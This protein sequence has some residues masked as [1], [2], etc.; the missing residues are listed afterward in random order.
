MFPSAQ[1][2]SWSQVAGAQYYCLTVGTSQ[3][4]VDLVNSGL[5]PASQLSYTVPGTPR[6]HPHCGPGSTPTCRATWTWADV[7][8]SVTG[9]STAT[10]TRPTA[11]A[12]KSTPAQAFS[13]TP[14]ASA[15]YYADHSRDHPGWLRP[16]QQRPAAGHA[17]RSFTCPPSRAAGPSAARIYSYIAGGW[18]HYSDVSFTAAPSACRAARGAAA[19]QLLVLRAPP[20]RA[21]GNR[22]PDAV[23]F[24]PWGSG[25]R[26]GARA[27][28]RRC[29]S[30]PA[31]GSPAGSSAG[32]GGAGEL[33]RRSSEAAGRVGSSPARHRIS[34]AA[35]LP[36]PARRDW[37]ISRPFSDIRLR[38]R[39]WSRR[40]GR[41][42]DRGP[43]PPVPRAAPRPRPAPAPGAA[44]PG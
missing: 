36:T 37:S 12:T 32:G 19:A 38:T 40:A 3:G 1:P 33:A 14:V 17:R 31:R 24:R 16:G 43:A 4:G 34:S 21:G 15:G 6:Q 20:G 10:F 8:F 26:G 42:R 9:P 27:S 41:R 35:R 22:R 28:T 29:G 30:R 25:P 13:W 18:N 39:R 11:G 23:A 7:K 2:F 5:L 44:G